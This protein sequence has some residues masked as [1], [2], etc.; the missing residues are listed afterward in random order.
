MWNVNVF[1][2]TFLM[3]YVPFG[4][5]QQ[6]ITATTTT[7]F[8]SIFD[9]VFAKAINFSQLKSLMNPFID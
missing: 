9:S 8:N 4:F 7:K 1:L 3:W 2:Y 5:K 6:T